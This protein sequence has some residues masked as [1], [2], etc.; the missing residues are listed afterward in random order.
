MTKYQYSVVPAD[1]DERKVNG[2][3]VSA[4]WS[5][6]GHELMFTI[7]VLN[8]LGAEGWELV[9]TVVSNHPSLAGWNHP[10]HRLYLKRPSEE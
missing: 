6:Y 10:Q 4:F 5:Y 8:K 3:K 2:E 9:S 1:W 7:E